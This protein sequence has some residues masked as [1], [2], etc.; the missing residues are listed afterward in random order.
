MKIRVV[1]STLLLATILISSNAF[2]AKALKGRK[3]FGLDGIGHYTIT[4]FDSAYVSFPTSSIKVAGSGFNT[5][6]EYGFADNF[7]FETSIGYERIHYAKQSANPNI[8]QVI[9][10]NFFTIDARGNYYFLSSDKSMVQPYATVGAGTTISGKSA[11]P[12]LDIGGGTHFFIADN[13]SIKAQVLYKTAF[14]HNHL[15]VGLG[16][17][18]HF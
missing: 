12:L 5:Y 16:V 9:A 18:F 17:G 4:S 10:E 11:I 1:L 6:F 2:A 3:T 15:E 7:S 14:I 8:R 13:V